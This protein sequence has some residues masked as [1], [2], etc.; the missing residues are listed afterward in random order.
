ME[1]WCYALTFD[2]LLAN[3]LESR[4]VGEHTSSC[5]VRRK[6]WIRVRRSVCEFVY[7]DLL[8]Q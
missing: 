4:S 6:R 3:V 2:S 8:T 7:F 1:G 5:L